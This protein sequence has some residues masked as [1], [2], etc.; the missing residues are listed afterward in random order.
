MEKYKTYTRSEESSEIGTLDFY[1]KYHEMAIP[2]KYPLSM[3]PPEDN[4]LNWERIDEFKPK[5]KNSYSEEMN[6]FDANS[7]LG[8][9]IN[10]RERN[11]NS[12]FE[13]P[14]EHQFPAE[15]L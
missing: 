5:N 9:E 12:S 1:Q 2:Q 14:K 11:K 8:S 6:K 15:E 7:R 3:P 13:E 10:D 4:W